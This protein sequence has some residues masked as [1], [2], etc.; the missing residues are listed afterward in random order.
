MIVSGRALGSCMPWESVCLG[1]LEPSRLCAPLLLPA[2]PSGHH[3]TFSL[4]AD[5]SVFLFLGCSGPV[6]L[7]QVY[8]W[9]AAVDGRI[10][11][12]IQCSTFRRRFIVEIQ[13]LALKTHSHLSL[14][15]PSPPDGTCQYNDLFR[16]G[17]PWLGIG[18]KTA[19]GQASNYLDPHFL[20]RGSDG[21]NDLF[22]P[23]LFWTER[24]SGPQ[25]Y[26]NLL[27]RVWWFC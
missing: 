24:V 9:E 4:E 6:A 11:V 16:K 14:V 7:S 10:Y 21:V 12:S 20:G 22:C 19:A 17:G 1:A 23:V 5:L 27:E 15:L 18:F 25:L 8:L 26:T 3:G 2:P 13:L